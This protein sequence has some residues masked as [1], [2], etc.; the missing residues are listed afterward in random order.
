MERVFVGCEDMALCRTGGGAG[1]VDHGRIQ[2]RLNHNQAQPT[3][4][5]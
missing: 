3:N 1:N 4:S 5:D 2:A